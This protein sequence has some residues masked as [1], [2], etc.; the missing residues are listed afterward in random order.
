MN[1][2]ALMACGHA[3]S[4]TASS[5]CAGC[6]FCEW[7]RFLPRPRRHADPQEVL[8]FATLLAGWQAGTG[9]RR[10]SPG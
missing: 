8:R 5:D 1:S 10:Q 6:P 9:Q 3:N 4:L 7:D 2:A